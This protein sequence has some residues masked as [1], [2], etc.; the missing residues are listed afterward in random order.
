MFIFY[1]FKIFC[2]TRLVLR[3]RLTYV[4]VHNTFD[5]RIYMYLYVYYILK[6]SNILLSEFYSSHLKL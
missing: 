1:F 3:D 5:Y 4:V 2:D 6:S